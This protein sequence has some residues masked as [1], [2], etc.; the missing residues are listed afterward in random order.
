MAEINTVN[1]AKTISSPPTPTSAL[2]YHAHFQTIL[3]GRSTAFSGKLVQIYRPPEYVTNSTNGSGVTARAEV[4][5]ERNVG[6]LYEI[7]D[8]LTI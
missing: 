1:K 7:R 3:N 2:A 6:L 8:T 5:F 4:I